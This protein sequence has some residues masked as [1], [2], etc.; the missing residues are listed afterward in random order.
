LDE[1][2]LAPKFKNLNQGTKKKVIKKDFLMVPNGAKNSRK[3]KK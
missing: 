1:G 3:M 2:R